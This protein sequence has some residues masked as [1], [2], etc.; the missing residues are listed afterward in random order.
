MVWGT[1]VKQQRDY[2]NV[3]FSNVSNDGNITYKVGS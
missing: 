2:T 1:R 3:S